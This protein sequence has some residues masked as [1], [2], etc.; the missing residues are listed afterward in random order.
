MTGAWSAM[1]FAALVSGAVIAL[2]LRSPIS[3]R[4]LA[5]VNERSLHQRPTPRVGGLGVMLGV[6]P[7]LA[8]QADAALRWLSLFAL[9]LTVVSLRDDW[10]PLPA[11]LR[12][13]THVAAAVGIVVA[14]TDL[15]FVV[16]AGAGFWALMAM[17]VVAIA[18]MTNLYNF[19]DGSD[20][21]A[22]GMATIGFGAL[23]WAALWASDA[24]LAAACLALSGAS[25]AFLFFNFPPAK[26]FLGDAGSIPL[27][28]LAGALG[29]LGAWREVWPLWFPVLV[30]SPFIVDASVTLL[31]RAARG[32]PLAQAHRAHHY[33]QL[34]LA[35]WSHRQ[36][37]LAAWALM[38]AVAASAV[39]GM[40]T[41]GEDAIAINSTW[42]AVYG[43]LCILIRRH[44]RA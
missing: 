41:D 30:F 42:F 11:W 27:G 7:V 16:A 2:L 40:R 12:L 43:A 13:A 3:H 28:F 4:L 19:M 21:L 36:L 44:A 6:L 10:R 17:T 37:A 33:Q 1:L 31:Q 15:R 20:G 14:S 39:V 5:T 23:G 24:Q 38:L 26:V 32:E 35:G 9:A 25:L 29:W 34:V 8:I 18:W 22:G